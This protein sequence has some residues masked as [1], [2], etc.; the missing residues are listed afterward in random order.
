MTAKEIG[1][2]AR[3]KEEIYRILADDCNAFLPHPKTVT[4]YHLAD[5][6]HGEKR[7]INA[8]DSRHLHVPQFE[9]LTMTDLIEYANGFP[10][11]MIRLPIE[12]EIER[13]PRDYVADIIFTM[14][15]RPFAQWRDQRIDERNHRVALKNNEYCGLAPEVAAAVQRST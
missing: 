13:L 5:L 14:V 4:I 15:G 8:N 11:V 7:L 3:S 6:Y 10:D 9:G 1:A 2:K 12:K